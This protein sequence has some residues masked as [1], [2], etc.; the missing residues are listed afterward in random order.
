[1]Q[2]HRCRFVEWQPRG[3]TACGGCVEGETGDAW[4][5]VA[6]DS[7]DVEV[8]RV[9]PGEWVQDRVLKGKR[10]TTVEAVQWAGPRR[11]LSV[12]LHGQLTVWD[13]D[14]LMPRHVVDVGGGGLWSCAVHPRGRFV[15]VGCSDG[16]VRVLSLVEDASEWGVE[17]GAEEGEG[18]NETTKPYLVRTLAKHGGNVTALAWHK[19]GRTLVSGG[20][21]G[22]IRRFD[23]CTGQTI[24]HVSCGREQRRPTVW[25]LC[26]LEDYTVVSGDSSGHT[27]FW[28]GEQ[29]VLLTAFRDHSADVLTVAASQDGTAVF[30]SG[31]DNKIV[32]FRKLVSDAVEFSRQRSGG[33]ES[34]SGTGDASSSGIAQGGA[35]EG[36]SDGSKGSGKGA[37]KAGKKKQGNS[38]YRW[39]FSS[40]KRPHTHEIT[41]LVTVP[42]AGGEILVSASRDTQMHAFPVSTFDSPARPLKVPPFPHSSVIHL[43]SGAR[44]LLVQHDDMLELYRLGRSMEGTASSLQVVEGDEVGYSSSG[45]KGDVLGSSS[46]LKETLHGCSQLSL[47]E[48]HS[49]VLQFICKSPYNISTSSISNDAKYLAFSC[50]DQDG[51]RIYALDSSSKSL[52]LRPLQ[53]RSRSLPPGSAQLSSLRAHRIVFSP[54]GTMCCLACNDGLIHMIS[55]PDCRILQQFELSSYIQHMCISSDGQW[56]AASTSKSGVRVFN[57]DLMTEI[58]SVPLLFSSPVSAL[59]FSPFP[60]PRTGGAILTVSHSCNHFYCFD[61]E[62]RQ[63]TP[64]SSTNARKLPNELLMDP[65]RIHALAFNPARPNHLYLMSTGYFCAVNTAVP[66]VPRQLTTGWGRERNPERRKGG[67]EGPSSRTTLMEERIF[68]EKDFRFVRRFQPMLFMGFVGP[69]EMVVVERPWV[70]VMDRMPEAL[71]RKRFRT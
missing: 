71:D 37:K 10:D 69:D 70:Q 12:G 2:V 7:A 6:R 34:V 43:A 23:V 63:L 39:I 56:L 20:T 40:K 49:L 19:D 55:L 64:W 9:Q 68:G 33:D 29:G 28:D 11:L 15:A 57:L 5:A 32:C 50:R 58:C 44:Q 38:L 47:E 65:N 17:E 8:W 16:M 66:H 31:V 4:V 59:D 26:V 22:I 61:C 24:W 53:R 30:S 41:S 62:S 1:M 21:D 14:A 35:E 42:L 48:D 52:T 36:R 27:R 51:T 60:A 67:S 13:L 54:S 18:E 3:V 25:G 45:V 46:S